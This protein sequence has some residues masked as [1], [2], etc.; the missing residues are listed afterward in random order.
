MNPLFHILYIIPEDWFFLVVPFLVFNYFAIG[1]HWTCIVITLLWILLHPLKIA[2]ILIL[3]G[4]ILCILLIIFGSLGIIFSVI[5]HG[6]WNW[7][8]SENSFNGR[9][10]Q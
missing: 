9:K 10:T 1:L 5:I 2:Y 4:V 3:R 8:F 7:Y 6:L